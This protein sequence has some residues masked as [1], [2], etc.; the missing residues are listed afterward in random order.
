MWNDT[1]E[2]KTDDVMEKWK[3]EQGPDRIFDVSDLDSLFG[4][5][6]RLSGVEYCYDWCGDHGVE[7][8]E[9]FEALYEDT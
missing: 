8:S 7:M 3:Q 2:L 1:E 5:S 4:G 6:D 9:S